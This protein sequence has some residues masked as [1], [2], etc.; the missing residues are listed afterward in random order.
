MQVNRSDVLKCFRG[1]RIVLPVLV[2]GATLF[3]VLGGH[4]VI[5]SFAMDEMTGFLAGT[6]G[7]ESDVIAGP[8]M[9]GAAETGS[10]AE[11]WNDPG[12]GISVAQAGSPGETASQTVAVGIAQAEPKVPEASP[13]S[14]AVE[15]EAAVV[16]EPVDSTAVR[17]SMNAYT[18]SFLRDPF[19]SLVKAD[20]DQPAR[21][22]DVAQGRMVGSVWGES[23]IIALLEDDA[24]RSYALKVG[25][26]V[27]NGKVISVTPAS[28]TFSTTMFGLTKTIT[29]ELAEEGE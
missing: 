11:P 13:E 22:L 8:A 5:V 25:D 4:R 28:A 21:L 17:R 14:E 1:R 9:P 7:A 6:G 24:G 10:Q 16:S 23:G 18:A 3:F 20:K 12:A 26:R 2:L 29:L 15:G 27:M 19:Y